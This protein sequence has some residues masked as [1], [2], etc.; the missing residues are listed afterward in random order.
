[1]RSANRHYSS[2]C[3]L[4]RGYEVRRSDASETEGPRWHR[5]VVNM[6]CSVCLTQINAGQSGSRSI[7]RAYGLGS[8]MPS[9]GFSSI[10]SATGGIARLACARLDS[11]GKDPS[12]ILSKVGLTPESARDPAIRLEV[13]TQIKLLDRRMAGFQSGAQLRSAR[14]RSGL[15]CDRVLG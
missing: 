14:D 12:V 7:G 2:P 4:S 3:L 8:T 5:Q 9:D 15:L 1:M 11:M 13:R 6:S 10:P